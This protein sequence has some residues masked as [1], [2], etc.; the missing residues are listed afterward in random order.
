VLPIARSSL[1]A[2][3]RLH[4]ESRHFDEPILVTMKISILLPWRHI[5]TGQTSCIKHELLALVL[6][7][8]AACSEPWSRASGDRCHR[9]SGAAGDMRLRQRHRVDGMA[10]LRWSQEMRIE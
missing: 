3:R 4:G 8:V 10:A 7:L 9:A 6:A 5:E 2:R 1:P